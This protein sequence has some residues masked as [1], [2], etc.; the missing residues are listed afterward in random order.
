[1]KIIQIGSF[2][3][4]SSFIRGGVEASVF[5][6]AV[7]QAK[8]HKVIVIDTPR[9]EVKRD[10]VDRV[11]NINVY[12]FSSGGKKNINALSRLSAI[13]KV[14]RHHKP[15]ICHVHS[16]STFSL[17]IYL[18][19][20][21]RHFPALVTVHGL[22]HVEK[23]NLWRKQHSLSNLLKYWMQSIAEF[24]LLS[25][26][27]RVIVD[28]PYV[29]LAISK[30]KKQGKIL[31]MPHCHVIPQG[32]NGLYFGLEDKAQSMNLLSVGAFVKRK[33]HLQLI[34]SI[35]LVKKSYPDIKLTIAGIMSDG[36]YFKAVENKII[37]L[38]LENNVRLVINTS[39]VELL[40]MYRQAELFVLHTEE[41]SQGIVFGEAMAAGKPI[42]T[43]NVGGIPWV[44]E[45]NVNGLLSD[46]GDVKTFARNIKHMLEN[47][48]LRNKM[49][50]ENRLNARKYHWEEIAAEVE[51]EYG[52][53]DER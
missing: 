45:N 36:E 12:R 51:K 20:R 15:D 47:E 22:A 42:V 52:F 33:G 53:S 11:K 39:L 13:L 49:K 4:D 10:K 32:I 23:R 9:R 40:D 8:T 21:M 25:I 27:R 2:P 24:K 44:V 14:I 5:G 3:M 46:F 30:Y 1:M 28:T 7:E 17:L 6:L 18:L 37:E 31:R 50:Q 19:L 16:T 38:D 43:T 35:A 41:E 34:E 48:S 26:C 29:S